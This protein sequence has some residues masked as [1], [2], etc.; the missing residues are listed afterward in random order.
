M[1]G[2]DKAY[3]LQAGREIRIFVKPEQVTDIEAKNMARAVAEKIEKDLKYPGEIK[4][5]LIRE[6]RIT[7]FAR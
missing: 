2:V 3:A 4:V 6:N 1:T 5:T 7:E